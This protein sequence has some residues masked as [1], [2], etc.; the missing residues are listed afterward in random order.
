MDDVSTKLLNIT[1]RQVSLKDATEMKA[2]QATVNL[3]LHVSR[4]HMDDQLMTP[5]VRLGSS[6][7]NYAMLSR[8]DE[9]AAMSWFDFHIVAANLF[10]AH[11]L[12]TS[13]TAQGTLQP[14]SSAPKTVANIMAMLAEAG[15]R[16]VPIRNLTRWVCERCGLKGHTQATCRNT[17]NPQATE[18]AEKAKEE[19]NKKRKERL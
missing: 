3:I 18:L 14:A 9:F 11:L 17:A 2:V 10:A 12:A 1:Q 19:N 6:K 16:A 7:I 8:S 5:D 15:M 4:A 13:P